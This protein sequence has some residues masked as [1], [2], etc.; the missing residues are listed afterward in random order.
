MATAGAD[1]FLDASYVIALGIPADASHAKAVELADWLRRNPVGLGTTR[2]VLLE[3]GN[4]L[5]RLRFRAAAVEVL[6]TIESDPRIQ[7]VPLGED[8]YADALTLF[9][10]RADKEWGL[11]DCT[12]FVV[13]QHLGIARR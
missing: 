4:A 1:L 7:V 10:S 6:D 9:R 13:M 3:I 2:A 11:T 5:A 8:L 12:S